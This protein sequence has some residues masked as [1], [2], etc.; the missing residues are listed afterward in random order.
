[1]RWVA[2]LYFSRYRQHSNELDNSQ[3]FATAIGQ[4]TGSSL[5][6]FD[7][8]LIDQQVAAFA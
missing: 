7:Q 1:L 4:T 5:Y 2:G 3:A 8:M 6:T